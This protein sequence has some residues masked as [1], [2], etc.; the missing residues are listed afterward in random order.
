VPK[1]YNQ[2]YQAGASVHCKRNF[3]PQNPRD[4]DRRRERDRLFFVHAHAHGQGHGILIKP[5]NSLWFIYEI[6]LKIKRLLID[7]A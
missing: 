2:D 4:L 6:L 5:G 1:L 3:I 7:F